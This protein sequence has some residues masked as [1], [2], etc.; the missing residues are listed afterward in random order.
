MEN[1]GAGMYDVT[2]FHKQYEEAL[3]FFYGKNYDEALMILTMI[4]TELQQINSVWLRPYLLKAYIMRA[5]KCPVQEMEVLQQLL[6]KGSRLQAPGSGDAAIMAEAWS[7][8]GEVLVRLGECRLAVDAFLQSSALEQDVQKKREEYSNGIF[9]ANYYSDI[10]DEYWQ[11]LYAGYRKLLQDIK[12]LKLAVAENGRYRHGKIRVGYLS[13]DIRRHPVARFLRPL[14]EYADKNYFQIYLY[15]AN[16]EEDGVTRLLQSL[17]DCTHMIAGLSDQ[18]I[19]MGIAAD[20]IDILVDLSGHTKGNHL[21]VLAY[22]PAPVILS[23]IG[24]FNS[25][26]MHTDGFLSDVYCSTS[27]RHPAFT[28]RLLRLPHTHFCYMPFNSFP[29]VAEKMAWER[30]GCITFGC[31][32]NFSKVTDEMLAVWR[33]ILYACPGSRLLLKHQ[34][35]D[36]HEG[37]EWTWRRMRRLGMPVHRV[38]LRGF[39][40]DYLTEYYDVDIALDTFPYTGGLTTV[41]ALYMGIPVVSM[42]GDRHGT[43]FGWSFLN[44]LGLPE[45][46]AGDADGYVQIAVRMAE[47]K[48]LLR[49]LHREL[50]GLLK[51]SYLM[52]GEKYCRAVENLYRRLSTAD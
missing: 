2:R 4:L 1:G 22:R 26:G 38:E 41:E 28:E 52:D 5:K 35:F 10:S 9:A 16:N 47:D 39:S 30:Q 17:V 48:E 43:R 37:R 42:Y 8:L 19:A 6:D 34:L 12:P 44:N 24:Y 51:V 32:N 23:G 45:L 13:A 20:E 36:S 31:F 7:L 18:E 49:L 11:E 46:A 50:R 14:L 40:A 15:Q 27:E 3:E 33:R 29:A 25:L 21:S